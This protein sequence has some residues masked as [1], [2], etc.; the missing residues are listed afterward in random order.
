MGARGGVCV[1]KQGREPE[2]EEKQNT[3]R[4]HCW[5]RV[6][7]E[8][9]LT[10]RTLYVHMSYLSSDREVAY[11][12]AGTAKGREGKGGWEGPIEPGL[13]LELETGAGCR[14]AGRWAALWRA[15]LSISERERLSGIEILNL[16]CLV[17]V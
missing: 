8:T 4:G 9:D 3:R 5:L 14:G 13:D 6:I 2:E 15:T 11:Q 12:R 10:S 7:A 16:S 1:M 17:A